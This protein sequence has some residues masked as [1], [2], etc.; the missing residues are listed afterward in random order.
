MGN[1]YLPK[2]QKQP[3]HYP[4]RRPSKRHPS[5]VCEKPQDPGGRYDDDPGPYQGGVLSSK[6]NPNAGR[7]CSQHPENACTQ[8]DGGPGQYPKNS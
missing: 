7:H 2:S 3:L 5:P 1:N 4:K 8:T 6:T